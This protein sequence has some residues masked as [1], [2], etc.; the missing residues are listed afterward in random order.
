MRRRRAPKRE[1]KA[2]PKYDSPLIGHFICIVMIDGKK[3]TAQKIVYGALDI[4][5]EKTKEDPAK[6]FFG[7]LE[8]TRPRMAVKPRR[9]GGATYQVPLEI[10]K[11]KGV[12]IALRWMK[13]FAVKKKGRPMDERLAEEIISAYKNESN[14]AFAHFR[15]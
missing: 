12:S 1:P 11:E 4:V 9:V 13:N 10:T 5:A 7:A 15:Y 6:V 8:N 14:R 2:D 3:T